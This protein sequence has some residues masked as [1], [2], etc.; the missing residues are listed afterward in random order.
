M[1]KE[2]TEDRSERRR[3][4]APLGVPD[5]RRLMISNAL[6]W[7]SMW[8]EMIVVGWLVL[9]MTDSAWRVALIGFYRMSPLVIVGFFAGPLVDRLGRRNIMLLGQTVSLITIACIALLLWTDRIAFPHLA[10]GALIL[11]VMWALDWTARRSL[12]PDLVGRTGTVDGML[13]EGFVQNIARCVGPF[14]SG[15]LIQVLGAPGCFTVLVGNCAL[16]LIVLLGLSSEAASRSTKPTTS[17]WAHIV[18]G[19]RYVRRSEAIFGVM[20]ITVVMNF[21]AFPY[22]TMLPV[23]ARDILNQG[24]MGLGLLGTATGIGF[25]AGLL[26]VSRMRHSTGIGWI[27]AVGSLFTSA[28]LVGFSLSA[29][30][31]LSLFLLILAGMGQAC[32]NVLQSSIVLLSARDEMRSRA[33]GVLLIAIGGGP[34]G[35]LQ[36][37]GLAQVFGPSLAV[38]LTCTSAALLVIVVAAAL[39]GFRRTSGERE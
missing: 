11:G 4:L 24:P 23:F 35:R 1:P 13:L 17:P 37:G 2:A 27:F 14:T 21:L 29:H 19:L 9:E 20:L 28:M 36:T 38:A 34:L 31:H 18:E 22:M 7:Q 15:V 26:L 10:V 25:F 39:P 12:L 6:W 8:M 32:F 30:F 5:Y 3:I 33:M 16:S